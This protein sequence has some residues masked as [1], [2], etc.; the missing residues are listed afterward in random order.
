MFATR[1]VH[2]AHD[3]RD[4]YCKF[5]TI[6]NFIAGYWAFINRAPYSGWE[7]H[8]DTGGDFIDFIGPIY[9][10]SAGYAAK[11]RALEPEAIRMLDA[12]TGAGPSTSTTGARKLGTII[13]DPGHGGVAKVGGSSPNN[14]ISVSGVKEKKLTLDFCMILRDALTDQAKA[15]GEQIKVVMTRTSDVNVG[16]GDRAALAGKHKAKAL[17]C[18]HFNGAADKKVRGA[19]TYFAAAENGNTN[20]AADKAFAGA[21]Q[22][23]WMKGLK[24]ID[25]AAKDRGLKPDTQ[26]THGVLGL[27]KDHALGNGN[28]TDKCVAAYMEAE[29]ITNPNVDK[30]LISGA[31]AVANRTKVLGTLAAEIRKQM[32][33]LPG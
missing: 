31:D 30:L 2:E 28:R 21:V 24:A 16:I 18:I 5:A 10:P 32:A 23:A 12:A 3:G 33:A 17:L 20:L 13:L 27:L 7:S 4:A 22:S 25:P 29:F 19:E 1:V 6:E 9:T 8:V 14:A 11:V 15:A 26:C